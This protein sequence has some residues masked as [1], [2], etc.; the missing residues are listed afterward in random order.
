[1]AHVADRILAAVKARLSTLSGGITVVVLPLHLLDV[2]QLPAIIIDNVVDTISSRT[3]GFFPDEQARRL[4]FTVQPTLL[5]DSLSLP[6]VVGD[7][8]EQVEIALTGSQD[9][10]NLGGLLTRGLR[11]EGAELVIDSESLQQ[12]AAGWRIS[13]SCTY[14]LRSDVPGNTEKEL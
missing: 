12:P 7:M 11:I 4:E 8:H 3:E 9:A 5:A 2:E 10:V 1:M 13:V 6:D 14:N